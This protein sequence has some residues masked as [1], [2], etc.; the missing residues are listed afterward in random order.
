MAQDRNNSPQKSLK[1]P[2]ITLSRQLVRFFII[3]FAGV[4]VGWFVLGWWVSPIQYTQVYPNELRPDAR[5]DY[6]QMVAESF[7]ATGDLQMAAKRLQ[8]WAPEDLIRLLDVRIGAL[9]NEDPVTAGYLREVATQL[10]LTPGS[11]L[12]VVTQTEPVPSEAGPSIWT[13]L[14][15][16][17]VGLL[18]V[19]VIYSLVKRIRASRTPPRLR[20][21]ARGRARRAE[22]AG[23]VGEGEPVQE[24]VLKSDEYGEVEA[25]AE[26]AVA[27]SAAA[28]TRSKQDAASATVV[29]QETPQAGAEPVEQPA[30][31]EPV[32]EDVAVSEPAQPE[33]MPEA[34]S[35]LKYEEMYFD[36]DPR[37]NEIH[38]IDE[39][40]L[41]LGEFGAGA[42]AVSREDKNRVVSLEVWLFDK[43]DIR[44]VTAILIP[45]EIYED[46]DERLN[47]VGESGLVFPLE[48]ETTLY[49]QT[50]TLEVYGRIGRVEYGPTVG[51]SPTIAGAQI[52]LAGQP[53]RPV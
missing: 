12:P 14:L 2:R 4:L 42:G 47:Y 9:Q 7:A 32:I 48:P 45:P 11:A 53:R 18:V 3:F 43:S 25:P 1:L 19:A 17:L 24:V 51:G 35:T 41:Y 8:Y 38:S 31:D 40:G 33:V 49:L 21:R 22:D 34:P 6:F 13:I 52:F 28:A 44:T 5:D 39:R 50:E 23:D 16:L 27:V 37:Y 36:G 20:A 26:A 10:H 46:E 29:E 15:Y 30:R